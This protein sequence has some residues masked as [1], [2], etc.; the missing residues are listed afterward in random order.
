MTAREDFS[1]A[2]T[3]QALEFRRV[4]EVEVKAGLARRWND[5]GKGATETAK[6][7]KAGRQTVYQYL[8]RG[9]M[10]QDNEST[11]E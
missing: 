5:D 3:N 10:T 7:L 9:G 11:R 8:K 4:V 1:P 2:L 6:L